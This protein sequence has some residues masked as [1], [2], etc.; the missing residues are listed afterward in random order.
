[1]GA[2][3]VAYTGAAVGFMSARHP[4]YSAYPKRYAKILMFRKIIATRN[5]AKK[6]NYIWFIKTVIGMSNGIELLML[7][8]A[9]YK[10][11]R[12]FN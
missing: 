4:R 1:M 7:P 5:R 11:R 12:K 2:R 8:I 6:P 3:A 10:Y 9:V